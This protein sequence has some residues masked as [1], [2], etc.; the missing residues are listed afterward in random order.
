[1][2]AA[3]PNLVLV[4]RKN[5][6]LGWILLPYLTISENKNFLTAEQAF[7]TLEFAGLTAAWEKTLYELALSLDTQELANRFSKK[8]LQPTPFFESLSSQ[9][10]EEVV[11]PFV[12]KQMH[13]ILLVHFNTTFR[14]M[15]VSA[16]QICIPISYCIIRRRLVK[17]NCILSGQQKKPSTS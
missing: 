11:L 16:G 14:F 9:K 17:Q 2:E 6:F 15:R 7:S 12:W 3:Y 1:M 13:K 4:A 5:R 10:R 8:K